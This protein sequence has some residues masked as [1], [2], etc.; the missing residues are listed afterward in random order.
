MAKK[1]KFHISSDGE[2][3]LDVEGAVGNECEA[4]TKPF[5]EA[6]GIVADRKHKDS[7]YSQTT[8]TTSVDT[9]TQK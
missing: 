6:L 9:E 5:E 7:Y 3:K 8:E 1:I 4:M 2:V